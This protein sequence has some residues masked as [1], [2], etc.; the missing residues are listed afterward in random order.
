MCGIEH[1]PACRQCSEALAAKGGG[2]WPSSLSLRCD[3]PFS[4]PGAESRQLT[5]F[6]AGVAQVFSIGGPGHKPVEFSGI[7]P[8][9]RCKVQTRHVSVCVHSDHMLLSVTTTCQMWT[10]RP[11]ACDGVAMLLDFVS[12]GSR[13]VLQMRD[14]CLGDNR[15]PGH[16][17][18]R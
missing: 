9:S 16:R 6:R 8:C 4:H 3:F 2:F 7:K 14:G 18:G 5:C 13:R 10:L 12:P 1:A 17:G 11:C 15:Q